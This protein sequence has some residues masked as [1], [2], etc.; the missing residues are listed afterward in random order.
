MKR[1]SALKRS[2]SSA[3]LC[4]QRARDA[5][6]QG[7]RHEQ[8]RVGEPPHL[9]PLDPA[10]IPEAHPHRHDSRDEA[11][12]HAEHGDRPQD[13]GGLR[14][15]RQRPVHAL[16]R[17]LE[18]FRIEEAEQHEA[19]ATGGRDDRDPRATAP[20][21]AGHRGTRARSRSA[22]GT[23]AATPTDPRAPPT[24]D[25][26]APRDSPAPRTG[27]TAPRPRSWRAA[28]HSPEAASRSDAPSGAPRSAIRSRARRATAANPSAFCHHGSAPEPARMLSTTASAVK[29]AATVASNHADTADRLTR[30]SFQCVSPETTVLLRHH[31]SDGCRSAPTLVPVKDRALRRRAAVSSR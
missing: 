30:R 3:P 17:R 7:E 12:E 2:S 29:P 1:K 22:P 6:Q 5:D 21:A 25:P 10:R 24:P 8:R 19:R 31:M 27:H 18:R 13:A 4:G 14:Q 16:V 20:M 9:E 23:A 11:G 28:P 15:R 26:A